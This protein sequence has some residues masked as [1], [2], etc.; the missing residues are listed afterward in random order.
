M[1]PVI[2]GREIIL[3][4]PQ[5][6]VGHG[7][8][9]QLDTFPVHFLFLP[10]Q[11]RTHDELLGHNISNGFRG[12]K[13][14]GDNVLLPGCFHN[15]SFAA[16]VS[17]FAAAFTGVGVVNILPDDILGRDDFQR[18]YDFLANLRHGIPTLRADQILTLQTMLHLLGGNSFRDGVQGVGML[19]VPLMAG[20]IGS[21]RL[22]FFRGGEY[23]GFV[24]QEAHLLHDRF[25]RFLGGR[26]KPLMPGKAQGFHENRNLLLQFGN[27]P[28]LSL[29][30][31]IF[32]P[33][34]GHHFRVA[35]LEIIRTFHVFI[36]PYF[37]EK[38]Q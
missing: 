24:K 37:S 30:L 29:E 13:A 8:T 12:G 28:T 25:V 33:G 34:N 20:H 2:Y 38:V 27:A 10:V 4:G 26:A 15:G 14:A 5:N 7:L 36:I 16:L 32:R 31:L 3:R 35:C 21:F 22:L 11:R 6:P 1:Q 19:L 9:A 18:L 17:I 23:L